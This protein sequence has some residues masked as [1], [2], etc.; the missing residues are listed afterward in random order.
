MDNNIGGCLVI[1]ASFIRCVGG[2]CHR[3][4]DTLDVGRVGEGR[5]EGEHHVS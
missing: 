1:L 5:L 3:I 4:S 2:D